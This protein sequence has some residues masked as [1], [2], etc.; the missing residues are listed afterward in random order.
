MI[1]FDNAASSFYKPSQAV[2]KAMF[3]I[4]QLSVNAG[5]SGHGLS[6]DAEML[7]YKTRA[8]LSKTFNNRHIE[9]VIFT[10]N[11][12]EA[13]NFAIQGIRANGT[14]IVTTVTEHNSVFRPLYHMQKLGYKLNIA[15]FSKT[16]R[17]S[18]DDIMPLVN[19]N[20]AYVV[21]NGASNVTGHK[22]DYEAIGL[23]LHKLH[24]P[25]IV[26]GAQIGGHMPIDM[27]KCKISCLCLAGHKGLMSVQGVGVMLFSEDIE[28][29]PILFGGSGNEAFEPVPSVYPEKLE[30]GTHNLPAII[31]LNEGLNA[32]N[33]FYS[34]SAQTLFAYTNIL[35][36][37]LE[38][39]NGVTVYSKANPF[40]IVAF[41][42]KNYPSIELAESYYENYQIC[43]RG[44]FHCAPLIH[45]ALG[46]DNFGL[47]RAS[48]STYNTIKE[49]EKFLYAT[50]KLALSTN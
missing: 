29:D 28:I 5:R 38:K 30:V 24:I 23:E 19:K 37:G 17:I 27:D 7:I 45:K 40:G 43:V 12:S 47:V 11:C 21:L 22:N 9:R 46:T 41:E 25:L 31:S 34:A 4:K 20:T 39:I 18:V 13:L 36:E 42:I 10:S 48:L 14:E 3:A 6:I 8:N 2:D 1:Y 26:D 50:E 49:I 32:A 35:I 33:N 16:N 15:T 44:G